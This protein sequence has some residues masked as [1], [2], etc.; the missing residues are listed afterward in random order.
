MN[1]DIHARLELAGLHLHSVSSRHGTTRRRTSGG[2]TL[3]ELLVVIAIIAILIGL[4]LPAVQKVRE[5][6]N[7]ASCVNDLRQIA[8]A[9]GS[10]FNAHQ[11]YADSFDALGS[12][13]QFP[14]NQKDGYNFTLT[15]GNTF[16]ARAVPA[17]AGV[18]ASADC[19]IDNLNHLLC[20]P[21]P[22]ADAGRRQM[23][24]N[25]HGRAGQAIGSLLAQMPGA[26]GRV[27]ETLKSD[28]TFFDAFRK[29]DANGDGSVTPS[30]IFSFSGDNTGTLSQL[31]PY[32]QDQLQL[33]L[34]G[35]NK[36][37]LPGVSLSMLT[38]PSDTHCP[39]S[40]RAHISDGVSSQLPAV[41]LP[42]VQL[43]GFADG[44]VRSAEDGE[45]KCLSDFNFS[46]AEFFST[47]T[48]VQQDNSNN[49][50]WSGPITLTDQDGNG[51]IAILIGL[52]MPNSSGGG[53]NL[54]GIVI[55][56][57]GSGLLAGAPGAGKV[58]INWGD[59]LAGRFDANLDVKPFV[60]PGK[61]KDSE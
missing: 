58:S 43:A 30:E 8:T 48:P 49:T 12:A 6:A 2:F 44:S 36:D 45:D 34:A 11:F 33:G 32:I 17:A 56:G 24:A 41:Q 3:I 25:I 7:R 13:S 37:A 54:Q 50:G 35:E 26:L 19:Q 15:G 4:L 53:F 16:L 38:A 22:D 5:A 9:E 14:N 27:Q 21:N 28:K 60:V 20:A 57:N 1:A 61:T 46:G 52:L 23:F 42:A 39:V 31:L 51:I 40:L 59:G 47:L 29:L 10:F 55:A 18:T